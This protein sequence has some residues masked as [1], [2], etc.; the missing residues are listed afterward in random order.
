MD[1][2]TPW[3]VAV[4]ALLLGGIAGML[5]HAWW[6]A[7]VALAK[8]RIPAHWPLRQ[9]PITNSEER[10]VW[11][12]LSRAFYDQHVMIKM[13]VTRFTLPREKDEGA[14]WHE[15]L[16]SA[17]CTFTICNA[18]GRVLGCV[19]VPGNAG[20]SRSTRVLKQSL[21]EQ[22][23]I[24]YWVITSSSLPALNDIRTEFLGPE[25][26]KLYASS[27]QPGGSELK[28]AGGQLRATVERQR[29]SRAVSLDPMA[30]DADQYFKDPQEM[31]DPQLEPNSF[32]APLDSR[33]GE[34]SE[35]R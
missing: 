33:R 11:R 15:L 2:P 6:M 17:Y 8:R 35:L 10:R 21:L 30:E 3:I 31:F 26:T 4:A 28:S 13:P 27:T 1:S 14:H 9:R 34:L 16:S 18:E 5:A 22:C 23:G 25:A 32:L 12:W 29:S 7:R 19:D 20:L 24:G